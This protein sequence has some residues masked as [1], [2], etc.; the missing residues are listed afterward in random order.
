MT[1]DLTL[2]N[3][4]WGGIIG[5][6]PVGDDRSFQAQAFDAAG[7]LRFEGFSPSVTIFRNQTLLVAITLQQLNPPPPFDNEAP[8]IDSL[9]ASL[10][11]LPAG[12]NIRLVATTHDPNPDDTLSFTW[13]ATAGE[14]SDP[15]EATTRWDAPQFTGIQTLTFT[16]TDSRGLSSSVALEVNVIHGVGEGEAQLLISF[17]SSPAVASI[18]ATPTQLAVGQTVAVSVSASDLD[19]D[20]LLYNWS[21]TCEGSWIQDASSPS[22]SFTPSSLPAGACNNCVLTVSV[23]DA[24]GGQTTGTVA[25]CVRDTPTPPPFPPVIIRSYRSSNTATPGQVLTYEVV[26]SDPRGFALT[27]SW[28]ASI[29][30]LGTPDTG[31][32]RSRITW[33]APSCVNAGTLPVI[34]ATVTN[35]SNLTDTHTF[36]VRGLPSCVGPSWVLTGTLAEAR[37]RH[38]ATLLIDGRVLVAG[39]SGPDVPFL[40]T[41]EVYDPASGTWGPAGSMSQ[42]RADHTATLLPDGKVLV[43]GGFGPDVPFL[44]TAEVYDP[45]TNTWSPAGSMAEPRVRPTATLLPTGRVLV[46]GGFGSFDAVATA[47]LYDPASGTWS[48]ASSMA[49]ARYDH[50]ATRLLDGRVLVTGGSTNPLGG[51]GTGELYDA[52]SNTWSP[53][54]PVAAP[55]RHTATL[56]LDGRVLLA[57]GADDAFGIVLSAAKLYDPL[58][59]TASPT[60][61]LVEARQSHTATLLL[62]GQVLVVG[63]TLVGGTAEL[64]EPASGTWSVT[65]SLTEA[66]SFSTATRLLDGRVLVAGGIAAGQVLG[67]AELYPSGP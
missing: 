13:T 36:T 57:G 26:A 12:G 4:V 6:I 48:P 17:N 7:T 44:A 19:G 59:N 67:T 61:S 52:A 64:Y 50:T 51:I 22:A 30:T 16:A 60:G 35:A 31:D 56:L 8:V 34:T 38:T 54:G 15:S 39:G 27:F 41:A 37:S 21:A 58:T 42:A 43:A 55:T 47:D 33:A 32:S 45:A 1:V 2:T 49:G 25:L 5:N 65:A 11:T 23:S 63:G 40:A 18:S 14:F 24:R 46:A 3:G 29:G 10:T 9:V 20:S 28:E 66:R 62:N 53:A